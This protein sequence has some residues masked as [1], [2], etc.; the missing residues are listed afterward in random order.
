MSA[1][2]PPPH[3]TSAPAAPAGLSAPRSISAVHAPALVLAALAL[4]GCA[5]TDAGARARW[6]TTV[7]TLPDGRVHVVNVPPAA[8]IRPTWVIEPEVRI[9]A[10]DDAGPASFGE[11]KGIIVT[12][13]G[14]IAVL[15]AQ[16][17]EIRI[18]AP[19]GAHLRTFGRKGAGPGEMQNANGMVLG[20]D[21]LIRVNDP[22]NAR[23]S[24]FHPDSGFVRSHRI[25]VASFGWIWDGVVDA[26]GKV[27][28][29]HLAILNGRTLDG[30]SSPRRRGQLDRHH[31]IGEAGREPARPA[32]VVSLGQ[33]AG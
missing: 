30:A 4:A 21:G 25:E 15:D 23:M 12:D 19:D 33:P 2:S 28:E 10:V 22:R 1:S 8:G 11:V 3:R 9:G 20:P 16:A 7:D 5:G 32:G 27:W 18:F 26:A 29:T 13:D 6:T 17:Q 31:P 14:R 24:L